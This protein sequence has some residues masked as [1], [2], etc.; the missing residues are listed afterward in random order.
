MDL[1][2]L[3]LAVAAVVAGLVLRRDRRDPLPATLLA[4]ALVVAG[5]VVAVSGTIVPAIVLL[6]AAAI[7]AQRS[8]AGRG[9][10]GRRRL[11]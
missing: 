11:R 10:R 1:A 7:L 4:G 6:A 5:V 3:C 9:P 2:I 8:L